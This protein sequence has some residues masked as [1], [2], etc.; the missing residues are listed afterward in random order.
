MVDE[1]T[2]VTPTVTTPTVVSP[3]A[4]VVTA[5]ANTIAQSQA[6]TQ[7]N[8]ACAKKGCSDYAL[9]L[10]NKPVV[11]KP[12]TGTV[13]P[14]CKSGNCGTKTPVTTK[15]VCKSGNCGT[16]TPEADKGQISPKH[17]IAML[18]DISPVD[19]SE[20]MLGDK[21]ISIITPVSKAP[22]TFGKA[23]PMSSMESSIRNSLFGRNSITSGSVNV[24][25]VRSNIANA[26]KVSS[27]FSTNPANADLLAA[28]KS[29][30]AMIT[31][32]GSAREANLAAARASLLAAQKTMSS[33]GYGKP[34]TT[35]KKIVL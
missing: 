33:L 28:Q 19:R 9:S 13:K 21:I 11:T 25:S 6:A 20:K 7:A 3:T 24:N 23:N 8:T 15:P 35:T 14:T 30:N 22:A 16:K 26:L 10:I 18:E 5:T 31:S 2:I 12:V 34:S 27:Q 4:A 17:S 29:M 1:T 32:S